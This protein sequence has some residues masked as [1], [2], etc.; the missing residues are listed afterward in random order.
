MTALYD[1]NGYQTRLLQHLSTDNVDGFIFVTERNA[2]TILLDTRKDHAKRNT[3][4][5]RYAASII[6]SGC[7]FEG[8]KQ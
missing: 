7:V 2:T 8:I 3:H 1:E 6:T 5:G 4:D